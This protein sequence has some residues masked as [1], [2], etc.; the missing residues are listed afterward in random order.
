VSG[1]RA[2]RLAAAGLVAAAA[3]AAP[4]VLNT[5][6]ISLVTQM[7][8]YGLLAL[9][10]DLLT[11]HTGILPMGHAG[12]FAVAAY[13]TSILE[14]RH[15]QGFWISAAA[16]VLAAV[17]VGLLFGLSVRTSGVYFIL[18]TLALGQIVWGVSMRWTNFTGGENGI[19]D[20]P[21]PEVAT[22]RFADLGLYYYLVLGVVLACAVGYRVLVRSPFGLSLR[23]IRESES[24]MRALGYHVFA[25]RYA[26]FVA[27][28]LLAGVAGVL[29]TY[30]NRFVSPAA[31]T[32]H[33]SAEA[34]L[35]GILGGSGTIVG[36][37]LGAAIILG[38]RNWVSGYVPWW[39]ALMGLVFIATVLWAPQG[40][41]GLVRQATGRRARPDA[42]G[43]RRADGPAPGRRSESPGR[44]SESPGRRSES[45]G[46]TSPGRSS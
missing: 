7:L 42:P 40:L 18:L 19:R 17:L 1:R 35:M 33:G 44:R 43:D 34:V 41:V 39:T 24:R 46:L 10:V 16:G 3:L 21:P 31:A 9:S 25:H 26:A 2:G 14:V 8:I 29:Y 20:V 12:L 28:S 37:F 27:S 36:P 11:G 15:G 13:T 38:I 22:V 23:G 4:W 45:P 6:W 30:W 5:Y 32:F